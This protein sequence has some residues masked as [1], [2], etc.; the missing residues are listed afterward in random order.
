M[1]AACRVWPREAEAVVA[2]HLTDGGCDGRE[3]GRRRREHGAGSHAGEIGGEGV[4]A[5]GFDAAEVCGNKG[6]GR[7]W[8]P[9][10][11]LRRSGRCMVLL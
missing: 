5:V 2:V 11:R 3:C 6:G 10:E 9:G 7:C 8:P 1:R 4:N